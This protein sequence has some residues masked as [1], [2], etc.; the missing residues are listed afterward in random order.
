MKIEIINVEW[1]P[2]KNLG[3]DA[4]T[5]RQFEEYMA[6]QYIETVRRYVDKQIRSSY[7]KPLS[8]KYLAHKEA[9]GYSTKTWE[10][11][12]ELMRGLKY[13]KRKKSITFDKRRR[14]K[15]SGKPYL[16]IARANEYG[17]LSVPPRPLFR[18]VYHYMGKNVNRFYKKFLNEVRGNES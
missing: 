1:N 13:D 14:H 4:K 7:W 6:E 8:I 9:M 15:V 3:L 16:E 18:P 5:L 11:T 12:G 10:A 17:N 2:G